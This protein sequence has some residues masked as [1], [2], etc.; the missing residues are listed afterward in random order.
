VRPD[1]DRAKWRTVIPKNR[2][3]EFMDV[4]EMS[5][6]RKDI[7]E[8]IESIVM[9]AGKENR[10]LTDR[11]QKDL[12]G[13]RADANELDEKIKSYED[14]PNHSLRKMFREG[15]PSMFLDG[16]QPRPTDTKNGV[17]LK[18][19]DMQRFQ[20]EFH[21]W[22]NV[23]LGNPWQPK[24]SASDEPIYIGTG[25][26]VESVG[27]TIPTEVLP[28]LP[29]YY[30]LNS[31][32]LAGARE[33]VTPDTIPLVLPVLSAGPATG[34][35]A[36]GAMPTASQPFAADSFTFHGTKY[37]RLVKVSYE[38]LMNSALPLQGA[39]QDEM[40]ASIATTFTAAI[41]T[42]LLT[43]LTG[44]DMVLVAQG[45]GDVYRVLTDLLHAI[46]PR[47][48]LPT[49]KWMLSRA[50]LATIKD[51]RAST[52][53]VPMF[54]AVSGQIFGRDTVINDNLSGGQV[55][56]GDWQDG[57]II[58]KTPLITRVFYEAYAEQGEVGF[59]VAQ[60]LD[61][62]FLCE[63]GDVTNQPLA[64]TVLGEIEGS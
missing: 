22:V 14:S 30:N 54:D 63:L 20:A 9:Q 56:Y 44:N 6:A 36:E 60:W 15:G 11:D 19:P 35:F 12:V 7:S 5:R 26:G 16:G 45:G 58:R 40:L 23:K 32:A 37:S 1:H 59:R 31:F 57:C 34:T 42:A 10:A 64:Y 39:I 8:K 21:D 2:N 46:P 62:H 29:A 17:E 53:G 4:R 3:E 61:Q 55:V 38:A 27:F 25:G 52:S 24:L 28:Y 48:D 41:T 49:N 33:I 47:F 43:A 51:Q 50:S 18:K 13:L